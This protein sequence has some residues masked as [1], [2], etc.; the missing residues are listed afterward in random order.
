MINKKRYAVFKMGK[1][2]LIIT[3]TVAQL[4][5]PTTLL[6][7]KLCGFPS[8]KQVIL[9]LIRYFLSCKDTKN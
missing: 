1:W 3:I 8:K 6:S 2:R 4:P 9:L 5:P 7:F